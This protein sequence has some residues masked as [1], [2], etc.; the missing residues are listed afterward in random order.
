VRTSDKD[1]FRAFAKMIDRDFSYNQLEV[2]LNRLGVHINSG[3]VRR[4][5]C[6]YRELGIIDKWQKRDEANQGRPLNMFTVRAEHMEL[7]K[8]MT[9][10]SRGNILE[11][12]QENRESVSWGA[13]LLTGKP[14]H[15][16]LMSGPIDQHTFNTHIER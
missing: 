6:I 1:I 3:N 11:D 15:S 10:S 8:T 9:L 14:G 13:G 4:K 16:Y 7:F 2:E 5:T 12:D